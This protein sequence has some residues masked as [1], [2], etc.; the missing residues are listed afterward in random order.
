MIRQKKFFLILPRYMSGN[1]DSILYLVPDMWLAV[2][3]DQL[4][5]EQRTQPFLSVVIELLDL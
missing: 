5:A 2:M 4:T 3:C 1:A